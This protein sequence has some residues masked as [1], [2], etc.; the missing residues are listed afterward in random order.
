MNATAEQPKNL[1]LQRLLVPAYIKANLPQEAIITAQ[2]A[3]D[4]APDDVE[5]LVWYAKTM[6]EIGKKMK[7]LKQ[8][9]EP[10]IV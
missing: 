9:A 8:Y 7:L 1:P 2:H 10:Q 4:M 3:V 5:N 6:L